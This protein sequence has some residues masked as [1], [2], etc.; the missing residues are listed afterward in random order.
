MLSL[1]ALLFF[2]A[3]FRSTQP[4]ASQVLFAVQLADLGLPKEGRGVT[5]WKKPVPETVCNLTFMQAFICA[6][7]GAAW[8]GHCQS[9]G[10]V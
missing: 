3:G 10:E 8:V 7:P 6:V 4:C 2:S 5:G 9:V 1:F